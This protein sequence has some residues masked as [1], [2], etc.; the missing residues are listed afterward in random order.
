MKTLLESAKALLIESANELYDM[1]KDEL[2]FD[3][4]SYRN[5]FSNLG[6]L[7]FQIDAYESFGDIIKDI[8]ND[9]LQELGY[10]G[11]DEAMNEDFLKQV[12]QK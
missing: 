8:E 10:Y 9:N 4:L 12:L 2:D 1:R 5:H 7:I 6:E 3:A 11:A